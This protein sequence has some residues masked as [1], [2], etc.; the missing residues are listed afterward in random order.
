MCAR[1]CGRRKNYNTGGQNYLDY[2]TFDDQ[3][4]GMTFESGRFKANQK[5]SIYSA[6]STSSYRG[7]NGKASVSTNG[8]IEVAGQ[9]DGWLLVMY[10]TNSGAVRV[11]YIRKSE[12]NGS[13]NAAD[14]DFAYTTKTCSRAVW[15]TDDPVTSSTDLVKLASGERVTYLASYYAGGSWAYIETQANGQ[16][17]RGFIPESAIQ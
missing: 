13:I 12:I 4:Y 8:P 14:L 1:P 6:P 16:T 7:A 15:L 10:D 3:N 11:G 5:F 2:I 9:E 17:V